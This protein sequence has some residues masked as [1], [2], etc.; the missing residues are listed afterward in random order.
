MIH[1]CLNYMFDIKLNV[2]VKRLLSKGKKNTKALNRMIPVR[3]IITG[4]NIYK[5]GG[6]ACIYIEVAMMHEGSQSWTPP[7]SFSPSG[8]TLCIYITGPARTGQGSLARP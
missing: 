2:I 1:L 7:S 8:A 4:G 3:W 5:V 6:W